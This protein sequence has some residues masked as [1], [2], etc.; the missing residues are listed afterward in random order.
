[1]T[2]WLVDHTEDPAFTAVLE[3]Y[4]HTESSI[5][6]LRKSLSQILE[7]TENEAY[8]ILILER[9]AWVEELSGNIDSARKAYKDAAELAEGEVKSTYLL[10]SARLLYE[11]GEWEAAEKELSQA[12]TYAENEMVI[13][14]CNLLQAN[15]YL[16]ADNPEMA[17]KMLLSIV[18]S[19]NLTEKSSVKA[20]ALLSLAQMYRN[21][22]EKAGVYINS[23][24]DSY[25]DSPEYGLALEIVGKSSFI[26]YPLSPARYLIAPERIKAD[27]KKEFEEVSEVMIQTGSFTVKENAD[28]MLKA[29]ESKE[30]PAKI[31]SIEMHGKTYYRVVIGGFN[32]S[33]QIQETI[34]RLKEFGFEGFQ[35]TDQTQKSTVN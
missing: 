14:Q 28:Y 20:A 15:L 26:S 4:Y 19:D 31:V 27:I 11:E 8:R 21:D 30:F 2:G 24:R 35:T 1:L 18:N 22:R 17:A 5:K 16:A 33:K 9:T 32:S 29:L 10:S 3:K 12:V 25:P 34:I 23:L 13:G 7:R 6:L